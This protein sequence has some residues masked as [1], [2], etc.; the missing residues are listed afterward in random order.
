MKAL[1]VI[2]SIICGGFLGGCATGNSQYWDAEGFWHP[3]EMPG[4]FPSSFVI[5][6]GFNFERSPS[7]SKK[8]ATAPA[9]EGSEGRSIYEN[10]CQ[11]CHGIKGLGDG[12]L[13]EKLKRK[14]ANLQKISTWDD[15]FIKVSAGKGEMPAW[16]D[17][18]SKE[19]IGSLMVYLASWNKK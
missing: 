12:P 17:K 11:A 16:K 7:N 4:G 3:I 1:F 2:C 13:A 19:E 8:T 10:N 18:L 5:I 6:H 9:G 15:F 14:P